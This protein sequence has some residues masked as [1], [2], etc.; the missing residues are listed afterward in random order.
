MNRRDAIIREAIEQLEQQ[1]DDHQIHIALTAVNAIL[2][3]LQ[4][5]GSL[6]QAWESIEPD[7]QMEIINTWK[8]A[9][10]AAMS[11]TEVDD[12]P[13][14][15]VIFHGPGHQSRTRC[16]LTGLHE[17]HETYYGSYDQFACW[18]GDEA[19]SGFFDEPPEL[20]DV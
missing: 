10:A 8:D 16:H 3:D 6:R 15:A 9:V 2:E 12:T 17:I 19:I 14:E 20:G 5:R 1:M 13:C 11:D 4:G 7:I 18:R